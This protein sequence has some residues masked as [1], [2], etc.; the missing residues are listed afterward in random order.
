[1]IGSIVSMIAVVFYTNCFS[2]YEMRTMYFYLIPLR[3]VLLG[4]QLIQIKRYNL[5]WGITDF[6]LL[7]FGESVY[8]SF[9]S[10]M[11]WMP[12]V[13]VF[14]KLTPHDVEAT[15]MSFAGTLQSVAYGRLSSAM[16]LVVIRFV[17]DDYFT[18][19]MIAVFFGFYELLLG[20]M[21]PL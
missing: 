7:C 6:T 14:Q 20:K 3:M 4:C 18:L 8:D 5:D 21:I 2:K 19:K 17:G 12:S 16:G 11:F 15:M 1:M 9:S 13:V 10:A